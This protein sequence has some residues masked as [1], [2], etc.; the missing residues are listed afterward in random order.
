MKKGFFILLTGMAAIA[1]I[2]CQNKAG[3]KNSDQWE[4]KQLM[5]FAKGNLVTNGNFT[6]TV[7][8]NM[9]VTNDTVYNT[10]IGSVTFEPGARTNWH[11]HPGGQL[12]LVTN[13][14]GLYQ[15]RGGPVQVIKQGDVIK[16]PPFVEHWH[17]A[18]PADAM[19]HIAIGPNTDKGNVVWLQPVTDVEYQ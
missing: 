16:C 6:G 8:L 15:E 17:G 18:T 13:G 2:S 12:L 3:E 4:T 10:N 11:S 19:T 14:K 9:L 1:A 5:P 7:Y